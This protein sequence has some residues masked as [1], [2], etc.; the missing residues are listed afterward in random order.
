MAEA[1]RIWIGDLQHGARRRVARELLEQRDRA[2]DRLEV[3]QDDEC[4]RARR[5]AFSLGE[6]GRDRPRA[7]PFAGGLVRPGCSQRSATV[8]AVLGFGR[9]PQ[10]LLGEL[11]GDGGGAALSR[12][13]RGLVELRR[14]VGVRL[15]TR[16]REVARTHDGVVDDLCD[17]RMNALALIA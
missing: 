10:S 2:V 8:G 4:L 11:C 7:R 9:Q 12:E 16:Q 5:S 17:A 3:G 1:S 6:R 14:D 15:V 13:D